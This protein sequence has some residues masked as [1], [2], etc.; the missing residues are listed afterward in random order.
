MADASPR[1]VRVTIVGNSTAYTVKP[2][3]ESRVDAPFGELLPAFLGDVDV[4]VRC[5]ARWFGMV[6]QAADG[7]E[8]LIRSTQP[9]VVIVNYGINEC[10]PRFLP[11][12]LTSHLLDWNR[13][14]G[15]VR[16]A[17]RSR[18]LPRVWPTLRTYQRVAADRAG[19]I[20]WRMSPAR[21]ERELHRLVSAVRDELQSLVL[22]MGITPP[23]GD[24]LWLLPHLDARRDVHQAVIE[25]VV[26]SWPR[27]VRLIDTAS[28]VS[29]LGDDAVPDGIHFSA[30]AHTRVAEVIAAEIERWMNASDR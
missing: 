19:L 17:Y 13:P 7:Y 12:R 24:I 28:V 22:V 16:D 30:K 8:T 3:R 26:A 11:N 10:M 9:D 21:F 23:S 25:R 20:T 14:R 2:S 5:H 18:V 27:G 6:D 4:D 15:A 1:R 29:E